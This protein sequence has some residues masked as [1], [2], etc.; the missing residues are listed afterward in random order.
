M[1]SVRELMYFV[2]GRTD[3]P[4]TRPVAVLFGRGS[5]GSLLYEADC[6]QHCREAVTISM[7]LTTTL[8]EPNG[9]ILYNRNSGLSELM[10]VRQAN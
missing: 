1:Q 2:R 6:P 4:F 10:N 3:L 7:N 9:Q 8:T 5:G